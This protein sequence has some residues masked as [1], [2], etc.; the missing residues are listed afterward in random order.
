M[1]A[2]LHLRAYLDSIIDEEAYMFLC[3]CLWGEDE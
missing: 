1:R 3:D 2:M